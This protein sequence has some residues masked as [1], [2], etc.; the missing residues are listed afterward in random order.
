MIRNPRA[1]LALLT[2]LN[3]LN[4]IDRSVIAAVVTPIKHE[5]ALSNFEAGALNSAFLIGYF[6][7]CPLF[8]ARADKGMRKRLI[9]LGVV[10]WS[11]AT[12]GSGLAAGF[13]SLLAARVVVGVGEASF[14]VLAP[15]II[16]DLTPP[17]RKGTAL[18]IFYLAVP[19]GYALG[20][21]LGGT[22]AEQWEATMGH[23]L[24]SGWRAAFLLVGGPGIVLALSCLLIAEPPRKLL[25]A[26]ARLVDG[27]REI[28]TIPLFRRAVLGYCAFTA[29]VAG[30]SYW[31]PD[32]LL[33][34]FHQ[35]TLR[36]ANQRF[37]AV[38]SVAGTIG[39]LVGGRYAN[40]A[41]GR[42]R[43]TPDEPHDSPAN[44][45]AINGLI[46]ICSIGMLVAAPVSA[47]GF[48]VPGPA[49]FF[50]VSFIVQIGLFATTAP[51]NTAFLRSVPAER[52]ASAMAASI[53]SIHLFGD[54]WSAAL[55]GLLLDNLPTRIAMMSLPLTFAWAAYIWWPR[56]RE[57]G[58]PAAGGNVPEARVHGAT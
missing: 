42:E 45:R 46:R 1:I 49:A 55:L 30:F 10:I 33:K 57:A 27:L 9:T 15:T 29:A 34:E 2:G 8:G 51:V 20:Y 17:D 24:I 5:L 23:D 37:G 53:F 52:R 40:R 50:V 36:T 44:K 22:I 7:T 31:V 4:Y 28:A 19:V 12:V 16:D 54:L 6:A 56:R 47:V 13:W 18:S 41:L 11:L 32:F 35:L 58:G 21:V 43:V 14:A 38:L 48:F 3:F 26:K 25:H 39:T